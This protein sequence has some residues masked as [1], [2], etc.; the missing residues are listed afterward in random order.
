[1]DGEKSLMAPQ[2]SKFP[3]QGAALLVLSFL[4][5]GTVGGLIYL[6][7]HGHASCQFQQMAKTVDIVAD[8]T[9]TSGSKEKEEHISYDQNSRVA[10]YKGADGSFE[11]DDFSKGIHIIRAPGNKVCYVIPVGANSNSFQGFES[12]LHNSNHGAV[13][14]N[15]SVETDVEILPG[16]IE[17]TSFI[18]DGAH[19][20]CTNGY[21]WMVITS[22]ASDEN[23]RLKR[24]AEKEE[25]EL[26]C[27]YCFVYYVV[28]DG[29][30]EA[31]FSITG[32]EFCHILYREGERPDW[33][34]EL[35]DES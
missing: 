15:G 35:L 18:P 29:L 19:E 33:L 20:E 31:C 34:V 3:F 7:I 4:L 28:D 11:V 30:Y 22:S 8:V 14:V 16:K 25:D 17:D 26:E 6:S 21:R 23:G 27:T 12:F 13:Q 24:Q 10:Y 2:R 1:M 9:V 32:F 5:T